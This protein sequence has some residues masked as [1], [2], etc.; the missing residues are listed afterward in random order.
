MKDENGNFFSVPECAQLFKTFSFFDR[1][2]RKCRE[3]L[4]KT[5]SVGVEPQM[6]ER[7]EAL[8]QLGLI[9]TESVPR[10]GN[11]GARE[12]ERIAAAVELNFDDVGA[13]EVFNGRERMGSGCNRAFRTIRKKRS[14]LIN[15]FCGHQRLIALNVDDDFVGSKPKQRGCFGKAIRAGGMVSSSHDAFNAGRSA[16]FING[17]M[18]GSN[19]N[20]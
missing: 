2:R 7:A 5:D 18:I 14:R 4:Q 19:G 6:V 15:G 9:F 12:G 13:K 10:P 1:R 16:G 11:R 3:F 8:G 20:A 17:F